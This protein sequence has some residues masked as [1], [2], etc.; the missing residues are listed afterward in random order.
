M[1]TRRSIGLRCGQWCAVMLLACLS[2]TVHAQTRAWLDRDRIA[3]GETTTLNVETD[4][5]VD[6]PDWAP[7][8]RDFELSGHTSRRQAEFANG[9]R[10]T[11]SLFGVALRPRRE[12]VLT[13]P[14]LQVGAERTA[15]LSLSV[16]PAAVS[17]AR[18]GAAA[19][20]EADIDVQ[21]PYV[22]QSVGY[23]LR[24]HY[25]TPLVSGSL[26]QPAPDGASM[27]RIGSD[28]QYNRDIGGRRY[29]VVE[30]RYQIVPER[31][32][33]L[34]I[35]GARF[36]GQGAGGGFFDDMFNR[37]PR[38]LTANGPPSVLAVQA[39]P[40]D[41]PQPWLPLNGVQARWLEAPTDGRAGEA[42]TFVLE[43][44]FDGAV[45]TQ[46]PEIALPPIDGAQ[47][48]AEP[49]QYEENFEDG[50]PSVRM[51]RQYAVVPRSAGT[52]SVP[53]P[54]VS[55]W[56]V[57]AGVA[58]TSAPP[59]V[60]LAVAP[61]AGVMET[62]PVADAAP[63]TERTS[64]AAPADR[65]FWPAAA[66]LLA[67]LWLATA[68]LAWRLYRQQPARQAAHGR[69]PHSAAATG[70]P[71]AHG[72]TSGHAQRRL[73]QVL[74]TGEPAEVEEALRAMRTPASA[75]LDALVR[76][77]DAA[78]QREAIAAWQRARWV[79]GD[80]SEARTQLRA[81]FRS[82]AVWREPPAERHAGTVLP[83]LYP[84]G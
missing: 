35:P 13:V 62:D 38:Q 83:P 21:S 71:S 15:L 65:G 43:A 47:V 18:D 22:Q 68:W 53:G 2:A 50:R 48:F 12:G 75:D 59:A 40:T 55:W 19:F 69:A 46:L 1:S 54:R 27:Q 73:M 6:A 32:G 17:A 44:V 3:L 4:G 16:A 39:M 45:G 56:D 80:L 20:I 72:A 76:L 70:A 9:R 67:A 36:E 37:G 57:R 34:T 51:T 84:G 23:V 81:A 52:L 64:T 61:G 24:L 7:L 63:G 66:A 82:G 10:S 58:R 49:P 14:V 60:P 31:S 29:S 78:S 33:T 25:A 41:A 30:R 42:S 5:A 74:Q 26:E 8:A 11:R 79:E 77:L 28:L